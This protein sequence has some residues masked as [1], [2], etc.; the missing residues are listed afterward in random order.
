MKLTETLKLRIDV[1]TKN[2]LGVDAKAAGR[3]VS[4]HIRHLLASH[5]NQAREVSL[6]GQLEQFMTTL[7]P[8][9]RSP[10]TVPE[11]PRLA[12]VEALIEELALLQSPQVLARV[13]QQL[14]A[15]A[16]TGVGG[17]P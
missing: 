14:K 3:D 11:S 1:P 2:R 5:H 7:A 4:S 16:G 17:A 15:V 6:A 9:L 10:T 12:R 13:A 8:L